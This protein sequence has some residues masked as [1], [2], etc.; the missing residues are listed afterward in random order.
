MLACAV[1]V[2]EALNT[3]NSHMSNI[4]D[5]L[6]PASS[7][8]LSLT[9]GFGASSQMNDGAGLS[10]LLPPTGTETPTDCIDLP[11]FPPPPTCPA[12]PHLAVVMPLYNACT[13]SA[14]VLHTALSSILS[15]TYAAFSFVIV[16]DASTD[17]TAH[18]LSLA[19]SQ[20]S[21]IRLLRNDTQ[22]GVTFSLMRAIHSLEPSV[23]YIARM[24]GDDISQ[25]DRLRLQLS[26][27]RQQPHIH[28]LGTAVNLLSASSSSSDTAAASTSS[29]T[30]QISHPLSAAMVDWSMS[31]YCSLA[32]PAVMLRRSVFS[33]HSYHINPTLPDSSPCEDYALWLELLRCSHRLSNLAQPLL[34]LR[35]H[36]GCVSARRQVEQRRE[37]SRLATHH[38]RLVTRHRMAART[39][40]RLREPSTT[41]W[42][43]E[44]SEAVGLLLA[45]E[46]AWKRR[47]L[48]GG[49]KE[50]DT[51]WQEVRADVTKRVGEM[52]MLAAQLGSR[53]TLIAEEG[54]DEL[55]AASGGV[56]DEWRTFP[57]VPPISSDSAALMSLWLA[58]GGQSAS[59]LS[60][61][62]SSVWRR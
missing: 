21:R 46:E 2:P 50:S 45:M 7:H 61:L 47:W 60:A 35:R 4:S 33:E 41:R 31:F 27:M 15:Q 30:R 43:E 5:Y 9:E 53:P 58:R 12:R 32:H 18:L 26:H 51:E 59:L 49:G 38:I 48:E 34:T 28:V 17:S 8:S 29:S 20:D 37:A 39:V 11:P 42:R 10:D 14:L 16:D 52:V 19:A 23:E 13:P 1:H 57:P 3:C 40:D 54:E 36:S 24:D 6:F 44:A 55:H 56:E 25:P 22:R 62:L